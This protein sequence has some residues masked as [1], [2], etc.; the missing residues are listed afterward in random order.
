[1]EKPVEYIVRVYDGPDTYEYEYSNPE[2]A[3]EARDWEREHGNSASLFAYYWD[4]VNRRE[5]FIR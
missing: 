5:E 2:H 4:G 1:M 3:N